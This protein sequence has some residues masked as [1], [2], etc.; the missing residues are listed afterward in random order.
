MKITI[1]N[2]PALRVALLLTKGQTY[3]SQ[4]EVIRI[5]DTGR[6]VA[7]DGF[8]LVIGNDAHDS[9]ATIHIKPEK[10]TLPTSAKTAVIDA[11]ARTLVAYD[12]HNEPKSII[13]IQLDPNTDNYVNYGSILPDPA[14][15]LKPLSGPVNSIRTGE[16]AKAYLPRDYDAGDAGWVPTPQGKYAELLGAKRQGDTLLYAP[17]RIDAEHWPTE[18]TE[19]G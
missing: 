1:A 4:Y 7:T 17:L 6:I 8:G 5:E 9:D 19:G 3:N 10:N 14:E 12:K 13:P 15:P 11:D 2:I 18:K 16:I